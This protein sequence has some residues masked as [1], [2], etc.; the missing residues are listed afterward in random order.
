VLRRLL[1]GP[2]DTATLA[3]HLAAFLEVPA[4]ARL[5][6]AIRTIL[7]R[8]EDLD[9]IAQVET[10]SPHPPAPPASSW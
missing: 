2:A 1:D 10:P 9:L 6:A 4:D 8:L 7:E 5:D 3:R